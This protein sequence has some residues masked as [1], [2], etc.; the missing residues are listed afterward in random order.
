MKAISAIGTGAEMPFCMKY[1]VEDGIVTE[2]Y[3]IFMV[4]ET[5]HTSNSDLVVGTYELKG[6]DEGAAYSENTT[7]ISGL[8]ITCGATTFQDTDGTECS[9]SPLWFS[10]YENGLVNL[11]V[12]N[13]VTCIIWTHNGARC[14]I[15]E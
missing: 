7:A 12:N 8:G 14:K 4:T 2:E 10:F 11:N 5:M 13:D 9:G 15:A 1:K 6:A 3:I